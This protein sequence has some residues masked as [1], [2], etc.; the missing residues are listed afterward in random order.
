MNIW[1]RSSE[2]TLRRG[3]S[4]LLQFVIHDLKFLVPCS[5]FSAP[6]LRS[7]RVKN[8]YVYRND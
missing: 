3:K 4:T 1:K 6:S 5:L 2:T 7:L 8:A